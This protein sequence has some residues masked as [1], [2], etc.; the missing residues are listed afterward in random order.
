MNSKS[1][2]LNEK[3][4]HLHQVIKHPSKVLEIQMKKEDF[5]C[6]AGQVREL[7]EIQFLILLTL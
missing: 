3:Y 7:I 6:E 1:S 4:L 2:K 5:R